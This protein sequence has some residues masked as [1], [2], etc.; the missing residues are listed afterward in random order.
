MRMEEKEER[1]RDILKELRGGGS[2]ITLK[3]IGEVASLSD[4]PLLLIKVPSVQIELED[5][6]HLTKETFQ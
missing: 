5:F 2:M 4:L 1:L 3:A 6:L